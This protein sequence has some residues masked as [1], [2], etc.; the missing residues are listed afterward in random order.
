[1]YKI[2]QK[3]QESFYKVVFL[4]IPNLQ[5]AFNKMTDNKLFL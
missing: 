2:V 5:C 4:L 1:M 3:V